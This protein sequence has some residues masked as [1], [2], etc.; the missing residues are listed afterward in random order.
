VTQ[1]MERPGGDGVVDNG[2]ARPE[3]RALTGLRGV[4]AFW[5]LFYH[6]IPMASENIPSLRWMQ[7]VTVTGDLGVDL[8]FILSGFV[9]SYAYTADKLFGPSGGGPVQ[10]LRYYLHFLS[11]RLARIYPVNL[12]VLLT[13]A[14]VVFASHLVH[15]DLHQTGTFGWDF[16]RNLLLVQGW[17]LSSHLSWDGPAWSVSC[18]WAAYL[19]FPFI[20]L[21][22][23]RVRRMR[24]ALLGIA[25]SLGAMLIF[26][27]FFGAGQPQLTYHHPLVRIAGEFIGG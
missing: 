20:F 18:E 23:S 16:V 22:V 8:F 24:S 13:L 26:Y 6:L 15:V 11:V 2:G 1:T 14:L 19:A 21:A 9:L 12:L 3:L 27:G 10:R 4:A 5:V 7:R 17:D 25:A